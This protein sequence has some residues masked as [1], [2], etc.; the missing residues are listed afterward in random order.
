VALIGLVL[1][2]VGFGRITQVETVDGT[3]ARE[4]EINL[5]IAHG[6]VKMIAAAPPAEA[7]PNFEVPPWLNT[8]VVAPPP[9]KSS[10]AV[11]PGLKIDIRAKAACPT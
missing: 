8:E 4:V 9:S 3:A 7:P 10:K 6:G 2:L 11:S 5:A 1:V